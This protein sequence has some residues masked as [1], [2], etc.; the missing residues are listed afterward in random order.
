MAPKTK[1]KP[2]VRRSSPRSPS[3]T[4][5]PPRRVGTTPS[6]RSGGFSARDSSSK[7][8]GSARSS[9]ATVAKTDKNGTPVVATVVAPETREHTV[10][11]ASGIVSLPRSSD[12]KACERSIH[13]VIN[14][15]VAPPGVAHAQ[16]GTESNVEA[17]SIIDALSVLDLNGDGVVST[18][19][20]HTIFRNLG[21]PE[22]ELRRLL[23]ASGAMKDDKMRYET[24]VR[25]IF[26][27]N[28]ELI[29]D[30]FSHLNPTGIV[31]GLPPKNSEALRDA[32]CSR[33]RNEK[34]MSLKDPLF[35]HGRAYEGPMTPPLETWHSDKPPRDDHFLP[36][37]LTAS[38][39]EDVP[40]V[41]DEKIRN[42]IQLMRLS[43]RTVL[44][45]GA[46]I[47]ASVVGQAARSGTNHVGFENEPLKAP[48]TFTHWA[49]GLLATNG[50]VHSWV[51]QNHDGLP[52]KAGFP[53]HLINEVHGSW[54]D[55]SNPVVLYS[56][57]LKSDAASW[58]WKDQEEADLVIVLGSS[59]GGVNA[60]SLPKDAAE[61]SWEIGMPATGE[62][63][64][65]MRF[66]TVY[67]EETG[68]YLT[69]TVVKVSAGALEVKLDSSAFPSTIEIDK[70]HKPLDFLAGGALGAACINLQRTPHDGLMSLRLFGTSDD[71]LRR[72]LAEFGL[73]SQFTPP[74]WPEVNCVLV[75]YDSDGR[76]LPSGNGKRMWLNL[77]VGVEVR[78]TEDHNIQGAKQ[79]KFLHIGASEPVTF[80]AC[81][82]SPA[83]PVGF[84]V[85]RDHAMQAFVL[86]IAGAD[87]QLGVWWMVAGMQG[88]VKNLPIVN[89][90]PQ[91]EDETPQSPK[92]IKIDKRCWWEKGEAVTRSKTLQRS[93]SNE[94]VIDELPSRPKLKKGGS[95]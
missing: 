67:P 40:E 22:D 13:F 95:F 42:L 81:R 47:S 29:T 54:F 46:G 77:N 12:S 4:R 85:E 21:I 35:W 76:L 30:R 38:E 60:D 73:N 24:F 8:P 26:E 41:L 78:I 55:P 70:R 39:F 2:A 36:P 79:P 72:I 88:T 10:F 23:V 62:P 89:L 43:K 49:L 3:P 15:S 19:E 7:Q 94:L 92:E 58:L 9:D 83:E 51:Q 84:V 33:L 87:M 1:P 59:L 5:G 61:R 28:P 65:G 93:E 31:T 68:E 82:R 91:Y 45:T 69:G 18:D 80:M 11:A 32:I 50:L 57:S 44:Y 90:H 86:D 14:D 37:W 6:P 75:P 16:E 64:P 48:P 52:Q 20:A 27:S 17:K 53:Q 25:W 63:V 34:C 74:V 71:I 56:G 66:N